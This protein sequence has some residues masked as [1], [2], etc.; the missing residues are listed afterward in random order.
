MVM[1]A[2]ALDR[3]FAAA[4]ALRQSARAE[5][6]LARPAPYPSPGPPAPFGPSAV[7][8][9]W[10]AREQL[11]HFRSWVYAAVRPIAQRVAGQPVRLARRV[12]GGAGPGGLKGHLPDWVKALRTNLEPVERHPLLDAVSDPN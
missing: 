5:V 8:G 7:P 9:P 4:D 3:A 10:S 6:A 12:R 11:A 1:V 2:D